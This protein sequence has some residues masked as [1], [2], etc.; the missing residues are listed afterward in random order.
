MQWLWIDVDTGEWLRPFAFGLCAL[1][2][3]L[4]AVNLWIEWRVRR[5]LGR[6]SV[7]A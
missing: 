5:A 1:L 7:P 2:L 3:G 4:A 6:S